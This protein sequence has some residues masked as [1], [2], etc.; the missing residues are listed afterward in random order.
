MQCRFGV[1]IIGL[2]FIVYLYCIIYYVLTLNKPL[3]RFVFVFIA[4]DAGNLAPPMHAV[5]QPQGGAI[6]NYYYYVQ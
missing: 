5:L 4:T 1:Y 3:L 2:S 6:I